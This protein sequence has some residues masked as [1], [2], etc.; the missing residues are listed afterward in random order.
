MTRNTSEQDPGLSLPRLDPK[1]SK[2]RGSCPDTFG[3]FVS[4][5]TLAYQLLK[6]FVRTPDLA[7]PNPKISPDAQILPP[8]APNS[9]LEHAKTTYRGILSIYGG[10]LST[11]DV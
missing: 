2:F 5:F 9:W 6:N 4:G 8:G 11:I 7:F 1:K 3:R 10:I